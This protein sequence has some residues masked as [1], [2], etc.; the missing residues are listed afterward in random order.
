MMDGIIWIVV[1]VCA[2]G[3]GYI[4]GQDKRDSRKE[5]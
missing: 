4:A 3:I 2:F 5:D 1:F